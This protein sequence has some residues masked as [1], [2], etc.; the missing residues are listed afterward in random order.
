MT[1][2]ALPQQFRGSKEGTEKIFPNDL[3]PRI[4]PSSEWTKIEKGL[5]Q[6]LTA[7]NMFLRDIYHEGR[8]L[9]EGLVPR[10]LVYS[11]KHFRR[12]MRAA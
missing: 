12:E 9:S 3:V 6:R 1:A 5:T 11:C 10:E 4:I 8:I 7:L 2:T